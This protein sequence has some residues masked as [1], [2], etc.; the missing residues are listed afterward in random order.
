MQKELQE[1]NDDAKERQE[2][3]LK[4]ARERREAVEDLERGVHMP[5]SLY[6]P[7]LRLL[8]SLDYWDAIHVEF[9]VWIS[10]L[11]EKGRQENSVY[12]WISKS[13]TFSKF[14]NFIINFWLITLNVIIDR[15]RSLTEGTVFTG[16]CHPFCPRGGGG[17]VW[18][19]GRGVWSEHPPPPLWAGRHPPPPLTRLAPS[20]EQAG[21]HPHPTNQAGTHRPLWPGRHPP[22]P[23]PSGY[24]KVRSTG[25]RNASY[26]NAFLFLTCCVKIVQWS[27]YIFS[28]E[29]AKAVFFCYGIR[30]F[31]CACYGLNESWTFW[32]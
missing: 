3:E 2:T 10:E 29:L 15:T 13:G 22:Q 25:G 4:A 16:V 32:N 20:P 23:T 5:A 24:T 17:G 8:F 1:L 14:S 7:Q 19:G 30:V 21:I 12:C 18:S 26:W 6:Y 11:P 31:A 27:F 9:F 28:L